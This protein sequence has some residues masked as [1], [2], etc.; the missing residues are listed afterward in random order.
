MISP[1]Q[2]TKLIDASQEALKN[3]LNKGSQVYASAVLTKQGNIYAATNYFSDTYSLIIHGEQAALIHAAAHGEG[4]IVAMAVS[5]TETKEKGQFTNPCHMCK[6]LLYESS[7]RT[8]LPILIILTNNHD[9]IKE[10]PLSEMI[11]YPWPE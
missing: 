6:Q 2:K 5:S 1:N 8:G 9:E 11:S 3:P 10:V 7:R 4:D